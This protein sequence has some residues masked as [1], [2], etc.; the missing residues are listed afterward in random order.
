MQVLVKIIKFIWVTQFASF[1][2]FKTSK[3][4]KK[5]LYI[6]NVLNHVNSVNRVNSVNCVDRVNSVN[7]VDRVNSVNCVDRANC[8][9]YVLCFLIILTCSCAQK[10]YVRQEADLK[11]IKKVA[12]LPFENFSTEEIAG[13][14]IRR[15]VIAELISRGIEVVEPGEV[16]GIIK[17]MKIKTINMIK[18][19]DI[20]E[21]GKLTGS[22]A[23]MTGSVEYYGISRGVNIN[24]P[25]VTIN[26]RLI[27]TATGNIMWS[28]R[29]T[30]EG[31]NF[32]MRH[33]GSEGKTLSETAGEVVRD[34]IK[35]IF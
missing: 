26:L 7:C 4:L 16:A 10:Y 13:E 24:Y 9:N 6:S 35:T 31:P 11:A 1:T 25:E 20:K 8:V 27:E 3:I 19:S 28:I 22:H 18:I 33:F 29:R 14:K 17:K 32:W 12:V 2:R 30:S 5:I 23:V 34:A 21:I 15:I